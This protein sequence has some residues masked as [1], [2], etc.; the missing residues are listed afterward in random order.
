M[1]C[2]NISASG[3][4]IGPFRFFSQHN[5]GKHIF[6]ADPQFKINIP[7][8][9]W[10]EVKWD[11]GVIPA[12]MLLFWD[13]SKDEYIKPFQFGST[14]VYSPGKYVIAYSLPSTSNIQKAHGASLMVEWGSIQTGSN[15]NPMLC[16]F[17]VDSILGPI[18]AIPYMVED[19]IINAIQWIFL[20][21]KSDWYKIFT[22]FITIT[23]KD[24]P[25]ETTKPA[26]K[27]SNKR[28][29]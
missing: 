8:Y 1:Q 5:R 22:N 4:I 6:R 2:K 12:K 20:R 27:I 23:L 26:A 17:P 14:K 13:I 28:K 16:I 7:W 24:N 3:S 11:E 25:H 10:V 29:K 18:S 15:N 19:N 21:P 9:D